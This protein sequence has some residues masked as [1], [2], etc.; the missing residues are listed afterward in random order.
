MDDGAVVEH[1]RPLDILNSPR[2]VR[3]KAFLSKVL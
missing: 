1:G 2:E 3:T